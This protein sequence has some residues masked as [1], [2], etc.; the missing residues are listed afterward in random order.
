MRLQEAVR[1][2]LREENNMM[3]MI[4]RRV[5]HDVL[6]REFEES[7]DMS[8]NMFFNLI[9]NGGG[10]MSFK[11]FIDVTISILMDGIHHELYSALPEEL[12]WR[13]DV[14]ESLKNYYKNRIKNRYRK[15]ISEI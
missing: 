15:L 12:E 10:T 14:R 2:I 8:S 4:I 13:Q 5:Q 3:R 11:R 6:E 1:R 9:K 7:L